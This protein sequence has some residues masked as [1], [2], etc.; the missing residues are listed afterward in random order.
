[1]ADRGLV[2]V[3]PMGMSMNNGVQ[4]SRG[5]QPGKKSPTRRESGIC[6]VGAF[7]PPVHGMAMV[8]AGMYGHLCGRGVAPL[9]LDLSP[10]SL[11]RTWFN[12]LGRIPSVA[13][14]FVRYLHDLRWSGTTLYVGVSGG[15]GQLY[16][17]LFVAMARLRGAKI[18]LHHHSFA[19]LERRKLAG[20]L[21]MRMAGPSATHIVICERQGQRLRQCY[22]IV[23]R[24]RVV[25]NAAIVYPI[26]GAKHRARTCER[27]GFLG[28]ISREK[29]IMEVLAIAD[30]L[31]GQRTGFE[32]Y[33][34]GPFENG[35]VAH[36]VKEAAERSPMIKYLGPLYGSEK[37]SYWDLIDVL[38]F[39]SIYQNETAPLVVY[40]AM[41][42]GVPVVAWDRGCLSAMVSPNAG[43]LVRRDEDFVTAAVERLLEWQ[44][45]PAGFAAMPDAATKDFLRQREESRDRFEALLSV[46]CA[47][48]SA[49][50]QPSRV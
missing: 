34:A 9:V 48:P 30:R 17:A 8:N 14:A 38:L 5:D 32:V 36:A 21:L 10:A 29:G 18:F 11:E 31:E 13:K 26:E 44:R 23:A 12:R 50:N 42:H 39:P 49:L 47:G 27:I 24:T 1:M 25:S 28:N 20:R 6:M 3:V 22:P 37:E 15:W 35:A 40:E 4:V 45:D 33:I 41:A 43:L 16:E 7:P 19:Y 46:L 2:F